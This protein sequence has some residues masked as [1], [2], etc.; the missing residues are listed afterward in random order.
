MDDLLISPC[1]QKRLHQNLSQEL[2]ELQ[3]RSLEA[4]GNHS[5]TTRCGP[6]RPPKIP[7]ASQQ[8]LKGSPEVDDNLYSPTARRRPGRPPKTPQA[9]RQL[10]EGSLEAGD[11]HSP[12]TRCR[13]GRPPK[14]PQVSRQLLKG[15]PEADDNLYSLTARRRP[16][17]LTKTP[18]LHF[19]ESEGLEALSDSIYH[20]THEEYPEVLPRVIPTSTQ[21]N[22]DTSTFSIPNI[23]LIIPTL[24][25]SVV[26]TN[27][28]PPRYHTET[29][30]DLTNSPQ[31][32]SSII[33]PTTRI[34]WYERCTIPS[35][36]DSFD[37]DYQ[38]SLD[39]SEFDT[40]A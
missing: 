12:T 14:T 11:N 1:H 10:L 29:I 32:S 30:I 34:E 19:E 26:I 15:S 21:Y 25:L 33:I 38:E 2:Q 36:D 7:Q 35:D 20:Q 22:S 27:P 17:R 4:D 6:G 13:P 5:P 28:P 23:S 31:A 37:L 40:E 24:V 39:N 18:T 3:E 8:L 16:G 9:S